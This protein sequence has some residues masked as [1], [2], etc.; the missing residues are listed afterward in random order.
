[1]ENKGWFSFDFTTVPA[2]EQCPQRTAGFANDILGSC[3]CMTNP[4]I[5]GGIGNPSSLP[6]SLV[7]LVESAS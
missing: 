7:L 4:V 6:T 2:G 3:R 1:M 5:A